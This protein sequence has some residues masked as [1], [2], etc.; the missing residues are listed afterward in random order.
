MDTVHSSVWGRNSLPVESYAVEVGNCNTDHCPIHG[1]WLSWQSWTV[2]SATCGPGVSQRRRRCLPPTYG[3]NECGEDDHESIMCADS[4][5]ENIAVK[6]EPMIEEETYTESDRRTSA[7][8]IG[9]SAILMIAISA[10]L[11]LIVD[12]TSIRRHFGYMKANLESRF[13]S[14]SN[15]E[16]TQQ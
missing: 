3:G 11:I 6:F 13:G 15:N 1:V 9:S 5:C 12:A 8:M 16:P 2:C 14:V 4:E 7:Q 10:A